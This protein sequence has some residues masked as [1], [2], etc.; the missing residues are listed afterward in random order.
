MTGWME[1]MRGEARIRPA[2]E[3]SRFLDYNT[4]VYLIRPLGGIERLL[5]TV[6][7]IAAGINRQRLFLKQARYRGTQTAESESSRTCSGSPANS[8]ACT[9]APHRATRGEGCLHLSSS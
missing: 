8:S 4:Y 7:E 6:N 2:L 9:S 3:F 1:W 5:V